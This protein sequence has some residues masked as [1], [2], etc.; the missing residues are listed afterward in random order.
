LQAYFLPLHR[1][2]ILQITMMR[3]LAVL[4]LFS[5]TSLAPVSAA[6]PPRL[7]VFDLEMVDTSLQDQTRGLRADDRDRLQRTSDQLRKELGESSKFQVVD[8]SPVNAAAHQSNLQA[9]GGCDVKLA[10]QL[11]ADL[12]ITGVVQKI[13]NLILNIRL[14]LRDAHT[15]RL[16]AAVNADMRGDTDESWSRTTR[17]LV[18]ERLLAPN[19]GAPQARQ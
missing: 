11:D 6:E 13:S 4:A 3:S 5:L 7:A 15:G 14:Y 2:W 8:I 10:Q 1:C 17:Y 19:Y 9:C 16:L 12:E 18:H